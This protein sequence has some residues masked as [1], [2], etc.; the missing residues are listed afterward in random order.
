MALIRMPRA[1]GGYRPRRHRGGIIWLSALLISIALAPEPAP[2]VDG[3]PLQQ[4]DA[5]SGQDAPGEFARG[6]PIAPGTYEGCLTLARPQG[7]RYPVVGDVLDDE[8]WYR[9]FLGAGEVV[10]L[11][12]LRLDPQASGGAWMELRRP[13]AHIA[14]FA[15]D[16]TEI[17]TDVEGW[18]A[19]RVYAPGLPNTGLGIR[20][21]FSVSV[22]PP[23]GFVAARS[24]PGYLA[25]GVSLQ[26]GGTFEGDFVVAEASSPS[27]LARHDF[28]VMRDGRLLYGLI[29]GTGIGDRISLRVGCCRAEIRAHVRDQGG[30]A[31]IAPTRLKGPG[32]FY[33]VMI[34][35]AADIYS[36]VHH[37]RVEG[38]SLLGATYGGPDSLF[39]LTPADFDS[40]ASASSE[41]AEVTV[42]G[43]A[44]IHVGNLII[45]SYTCG[46]QVGIAECTVAPPDGSVERG[47]GLWLFV[48]GNPGTWTFTR[49]LVAADLTGFAVFGANVQLPL[50]N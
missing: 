31:L 28:F 42:Q 47:N 48:P 45:G 49:E 6:L 24:G 41:Q 9:V 1:E 38:G 5:G 35:H 15:G 17:V 18:W 21:R 14:G 39:A 46:R 30:G 43:R 50:G 7:F 40:T 12:L 29:G 20:Y 13:D 10:T 33:I 3:C 32:T 36:L 2:A 19:L 26:K 34:V 11:E 37:V 22:L 23:D 8:D 27:A 25:V 4:N 44:S 16:R